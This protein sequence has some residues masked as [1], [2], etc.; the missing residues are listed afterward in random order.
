MKS[1]DDLPYALVGTVFITTCFVLG[2]LLVYRHNWQLIA[3]PVA[4]LVFGPV[5][6]AIVLRS[7]R[8]RLSATMGELKK[9]MKKSESGG[10][11]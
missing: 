3:G 11:L 6:S 10:P 7:K 2:T 8:L 5:M 9:A 4:G 1:I